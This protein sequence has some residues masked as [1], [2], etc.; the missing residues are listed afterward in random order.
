[1]EHDVTRLASKQFTT[2]V[3]S[4]FERMSSHR[5]ITRESTTLA[6][7]FTQSKDLDISLAALQF[8]LIS[9]AEQFQYLPLAFQH[10]RSFSEN[11]QYEQILAIQV[12]RWAS[13]ISQKLSDQVSSTSPN[14]RMLL[15]RLNTWRERQPSE[16]PNLQGLFQ[17]LERK[18]E[19]FRSF[20]GP[21]DMGLRISFKEL[22]DAFPY[23]QDLMLDVRT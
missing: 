23:Q 2:L 5:I 9:A 12:M 16:M 22:R 19:E 14:T 7:T 18:C 6:V 13:Q 15:N 3:T 4:T 20:E 8:L 1:M 10:L 21:K 17:G 11:G